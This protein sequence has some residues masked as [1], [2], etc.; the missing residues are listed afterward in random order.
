MIVEKARDQRLN[1]YAPNRKGDDVIDTIKKGDRLV[2]GSTLESF[3]RKITLKAARYR[4]PTIR[5]HWVKV[6]MRR[7]S[8]R[9]CQWILIQTQMLSERF[10]FY[11]LYVE[12]WAMS[13]WSCLQIS[14]NIPAAYRDPHSNVS[15][16]SFVI[17]SGPS[18][19]NRGGESFAIMQIPPSVMI[20]CAS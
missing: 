4:D 9:S 5:W 18:L 16:S 7:R 11:C 6:S 15:S 10:V 14:S 12:T 1:E 8:T 13:P 19:C 2:R 20:S 17:V 3:N